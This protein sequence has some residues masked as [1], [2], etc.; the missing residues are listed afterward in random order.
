MKYE[1]QYEKENIKQE[2]TLKPAPKFSAEQDAEAL[3]KAMKGV[4]MLCGV[5]KD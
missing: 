1:T 2:G 5:L 4:G 3:R